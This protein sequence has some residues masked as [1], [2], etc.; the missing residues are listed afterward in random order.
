MSSSKTTTKNS[1]HLFNEFIRFH[2]V[3]IVAKEI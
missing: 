1:S 2:I 3:K